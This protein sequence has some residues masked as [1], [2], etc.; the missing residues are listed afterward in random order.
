VTVEDLPPALEVSQ[1]RL[2]PDTEVGK[3]SRDQR[4]T[5]RNRGGLDATGLRVVRSGA[6]RRDFRVGQPLSKVLEG[7]QT[8]LF[9]AR[10]R[11]QAEGIRRARFT[12]LS[13]GVPVTVGARG[14]GLAKPV[15]RP[16]RSINP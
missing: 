2:F 14:R 9:R 1:P 11:P 13:D 6:G 7:G 3:R 16:P 8:T 15:I 10:F 12:V 4:I 5:I